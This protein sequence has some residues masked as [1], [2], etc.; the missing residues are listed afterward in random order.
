[1]SC[2]AEFKMILRTLASRSQTAAGETAELIEESISR[3]NEGTKIAEQTAE[4]LR[5]IVDDVS[6]VV[7]KMK[8]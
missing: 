2:L 4:A 6:K 5:T 7:F 3:V 1:M 8:K